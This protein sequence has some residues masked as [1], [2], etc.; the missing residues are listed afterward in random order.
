MIKRAEDL[1]C[2]ESRI[3]TGIQQ[4]YFSSSTYPSILISDAMR[5]KSARPLQ[6][7]TIPIAAYDARRAGPRI[8]LL[9]SK[10]TAE[11]RRIQPAIS[12]ISDRWKSF[13]TTQLWRGK[14]SQH[15]QRDGPR[16]PRNRPYE[17]KSGEGRPGCR[18]ETHK[19]AEGLPR[20][21]SIPSCRHETSDG[22]SRCKNSTSRDRSFR[23][24]PAPDIQTSRSRQTKV[25]RSR[26]C[27]S[28]ALRGF[29]LANPFQNRL[30]I[31]GP[32]RSC[33][34][35]SRAFMPRRA[36]GRSVARRAR[37][38][39]RSHESPLRNTIPSMPG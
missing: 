24:S 7:T 25:P 12:G 23:V 39:E 19:G 36:R 32:G 14:K 21:R 18:C 5:G 27:G 34:I 35:F 28:V 10:A 30:G 33:R 11:T 29:A 22:C 16:G 2:R 8:V 17:Q 37:T 20:Q 3:A 13:P 31:V 26:T 9:L 15:V 38:P 6:L 4:T 1:F